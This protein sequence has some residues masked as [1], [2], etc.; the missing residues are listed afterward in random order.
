MAE[1]SMMWGGTS[2][3]DA[4]P[5]E[6][7]DFTDWLRKMF[8]VDNTVEGVL[9]GYANKLQVTNP[10][11]NTIRVATGAALIDGKF[12]ENTDVKDSTI[13]NPSAGNNRYDRVV[14]R[15]D[16]VSQTIRIAI[17][18]GTEAASP[19]VP[20]VTQIDEDTWEISICRIYITDAGVITLTD[21]REYLR[22]ELAKVDERQGGSATA[23]GTAGSTS[24]V[25][26]A[27]N[28]YVGTA[29]L[30]VSGGSATGTVTVIYGTALAYT[31]VVVVIGNNADYILAVTANTNISFTVT[32][33]HRSGGTGGA[34]ITVYWMALGPR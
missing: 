33:Q 17:L 26:G 7:Y 19:T 1:I 20:T 30:T 8:V 13:S 2:T 4:G 31:A 29:T 15:K 28:L 11:G 12:Y 9:A 3:G 10:A 22:F 24:Y 27:A 18:T 16:W 32:A 5:Y 23:W 25:P 34:T 6:D 21:E 14:L